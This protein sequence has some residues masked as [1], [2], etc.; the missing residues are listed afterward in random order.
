MPERSEASRRPHGLHGL[1]EIKQWNRS[2]TGNCGNEPSGDRPDGSFYCW[3]ALAG[4]RR[5]IRS[6]D[7]LRPHGDVDR[8]ARTLSSWMPLHGAMRF[9]FPT[10]S[11]D[12]PTTP[13][14]RG[15]LSPGRVTDNQDIDSYRAWF[16]SGIDGIPL[17]LRRKSVMK[18]LERV[19]L[20]SPRSRDQIYSQ[21][22]CCFRLLLADECRAHSHRHND[23][24]FQKTVWLIRP[25]HGKREGHIRL[26]R[27]CD[28]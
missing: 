9:V 2:R 7:P 15:E 23:L 6:Q 20:D 1:A 12:S 21:S 4:A 16:H 17:S 19:C 26:Q 8:N 13:R 27:K 24:E 22:H 28:R 3:A 14:R 18:K 10:S 25:C 11:P 5:S